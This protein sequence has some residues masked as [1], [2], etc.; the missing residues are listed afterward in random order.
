MKIEVS[1]IIRS[2][3]RTFA[4]E[5][6]SDARVVVRV[7]L[8]ASNDMVEKII[9]KR[10]SWIHQKQTLA[11]ERLRL[12]PSRG[13]VDGEGF[14][15]LGGTYRLTVVDGQSVPLLFDGGFLL[16]RDHAGRARDL[17]IGWYRQE[18]LRKI[19]ERVLYH[20][21]VSAINYGRVRVTGAGKRWGSCGPNGSLNFSWR[22][23]MAPLGVV[24]YVV[25]HE[26]AHIYEKSHSKRFWLK[27]A[28]LCPDYREHEKWLN[29]NGHT[30]V[31]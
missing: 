18:A 23:I 27:V 30:L 7:P 28:E 19:S 25:L 29:D 8:R 14:M 15:Y 20:A 2:R 9:D 5:V 6:H 17:F 26:L 16:S 11:R 24:D 12:V 3:R 22:L 1:E 4:I 13:F 21:S 10:R 31:I